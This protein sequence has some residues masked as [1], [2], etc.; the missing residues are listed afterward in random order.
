LGRFVV[1]I[2]M[3]MYEMESRLTS[4]RMRDM[5]EDKRRNQG[6]HWGG[7]PLGGEREEKRQLIP[8]QKTD[9]IEDETR[10]FC[11]ARTE[12]VKPSASGT[13]SY[14]QVADLLN[15]SG[16]RFYDRYGKVGEWNEERVRGVVG[17]WRLYQ[18]Q[19]PL[20]NPIKDKSLE[21]VEG[22]HSPILP[23]E[24]C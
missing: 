7:V 8:T 16:W 6:R 22:G 11:D 13:F 1:T 17:R 9:T 14:E 23:A 3:A 4:V 12:C 15:I 24:L 10:Y 21:Y 19:L 2:L 18:G 5:I 20:G